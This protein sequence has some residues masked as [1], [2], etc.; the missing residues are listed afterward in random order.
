MKLNDRSFNRTR[1]AVALTLAI[2][3]MTMMATPASAQ[4]LDENKTYEADTVITAGV[5]APLPDVTNFGLASRNQDVVI[6][7]AT[8]KT[9]TVKSAENHSAQYVYGVLSQQNLTF[10]NGTLNIDVTGK[11]GSVN[12]VTGMYA[13]GGDYRS[14]VHNSLVAR[15][16]TGTNT[17]TKVS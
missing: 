13:E 6:D 8:G 10:N 4:V 3:S 11:T 7:I 9:L 17:S 12:K 15:T 16:N 2:G 1:L 5:K 14:S